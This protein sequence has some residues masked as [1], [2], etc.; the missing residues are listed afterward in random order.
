[1][2]KNQRWGTVRRNEG[3]FQGSCPRGKESSLECVLLYGR[4][5]KRKDKAGR[6]S[7]LRGGKTGKNREKYFRTS[8]VVR[9]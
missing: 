6:T 2:E 8:G 4:S 9:H 7:I 3:P 1:L 5:E